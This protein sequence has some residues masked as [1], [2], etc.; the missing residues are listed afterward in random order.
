M[1]IAWI[2]YG[3]EELCVQNVN[4]LA[5]EHEVLLVM[6]HPQPGE[7]QYAISDR[8]KHFG[9][10]EPRLRQPLRQLSCVAA[11]RR[12]I[13]AFKPD[14]VHF[15]QGHMWFNTAL[16]SLKRYPLVA[17][18]HDPRHHAGDMSSRKT[19]QWV[20]DYGF[21]KA[22]HVIVHGEALAAQVQQLFGFASD[23]VH[24]V[25]H[26]AMGQVEG[27][28][29]V[30]EEPHNV[31]FF[32]RIWDY[33]GLEYLIAAEPLI[34]AEVPDAKIVIAGRGDDFSRY[35]KL[36]G[37]SPRFEI[38]NRWISDQQRAEFFQRA[39]IVVL[40]YTEATQS[41]VVPVAQM[42]AK[43]VVATRVGALAECVLD[44]QT[45][46]LVPPRDP[47]ALATAIIQLL[48]DPAQRRALGDAG[49]DRLQAEA[50]P[51]VVAR[52]TVAVYE[53]AI[54]DRQRG[55]K[56]S[57]AQA[58]AVQSTQTIGSPSHVNQ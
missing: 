28:S 7:T 16:R 53:Q 20:M 15:Q 26:V 33:K 58:S 39:A 56:P 12:Q 32:G 11:I 49:F 4:A 13:D 1:R 25:A 51:A 14:V 17:T 6:P 54:A 38:H 46:L 18:I 42:Y 45:G 30:P 21:R 48:K 50:S 43:P 3:F 22:D 36:I 37:D 57:P 35:Q 8:V 52:Q 31:L 34:A 5:E 44:R 19:P 27:A 24:V 41:G 40:P 23:R 9:F 55:S 2:S 29:A 47:Q 10:D